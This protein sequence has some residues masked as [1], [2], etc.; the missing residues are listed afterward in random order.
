M[1]NR[2]IFF[3]LKG[4]NMSQAKFHPCAQPECRTLTAHELCEQHREPE[5]P[6]DLWAKN[7]VE[8]QKNVNRLASLRTELDELRGN[9]TR[10]NYD[11]FQPTFSHSFSH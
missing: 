2:A 3:N 7:D 9:E 4:N 8:P 6:H 1:I 11:G 10:S 5:P